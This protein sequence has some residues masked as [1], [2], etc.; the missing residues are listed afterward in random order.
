MLHAIAIAEAVAATGAAMFAM[1][2]WSIASKEAARLAGVVQRLDMEVQSRITD[3]CTLS[4]ELTAIDK[5]RR[6]KP[7]PTKRV[8]Q[9]ALV[10]SKT[11][12]LRSE[13]IR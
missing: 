4:A 10:A 13:V 9:L 8:A 1:W 6:A 11:A 2:R 5:R 3:I 12:Q 7:G